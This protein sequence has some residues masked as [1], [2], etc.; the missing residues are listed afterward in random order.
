MIIDESHERRIRVKMR[1]DHVRALCIEHLDIS[2]ET[3]DEILDRLG[4]SA[5]RKPSEI[6]KDGIEWKSGNFSLTGYAWIEGKISTV[7]LFGPEK[8]VAD[9]S[10]AI[11]PHAGERHIVS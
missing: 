5:T 7:D 1:K 3:I 2:A 9:A 6:Q 11:A 8:L 10:A 4:I